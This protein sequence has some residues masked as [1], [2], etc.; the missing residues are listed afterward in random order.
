MDTGGTQVLR[1]G[2]CDDDEKFGLELEGYLLEYAQKKNLVIDTQT[3]TNDR[4]ILSNIESEGLFD[5]L[6]LDIE[7]EGTTGVDLGKKLRADIKNEPM[8]IVYVSS[9]EGY[10]MQLFDTRPMNFIIK[11]VTY[12]M[13]ERIMDEYGRLYKFQPDFF[14]Y[15][16]GKTKYKVSE[17]YIFYFQSQGK[18]IQIVTQ[19]E[20]KEFY[21][22]LS[23]VLQRLNND[24]FCCVHK[25]YVI[26]LRYVLEFGKD[27]ILMAN[28]ERI[29][30]SRAMRKNLNNTILK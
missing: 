12:K 3:F 8:Q 13:I 11:P 26:N 2:I 22:K 23:E 19:N 1:I 25:S 16:I 6:F 21:G 17:Q 18:K 24:S 20:T 4:D 9:K 14:E 28:G 7:L 27:S 15:N 10:A 30:V 29:P 5:I